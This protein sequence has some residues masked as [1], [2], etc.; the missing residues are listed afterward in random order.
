MTAYLGLAAVYVVLA[1][2]VLVVTTLL[3]GLLWDA[4]LAKSEGVTRST[5]LQAARVVVPLSVVALFVVALIDPAPF[6]LSCHC[7]GHGL[8]H[9]HLCWL[10]PHHAQ[11]MIA[12]AV[13]V[14]LPLLGLFA[15]RAGLLI[16]RVVRAEW[17]VARVR[18]L[19]VTQV[20]GIDVRLADCPEVGAF[21]A[22][23]LRPLVVFDRTLFEHLSPPHRDAIVLHEAAHQARRDPLTNV[24]L[25]AA[26]AVLPRR[27]VEPRVSGWQHASEERCDEAAAIELNSSVVVAE[28]LLEVGRSRHPGG[29]RPAFG[30]SAAR[31]QLKGRV[32]RLLALDPAT[33]RYR[34]QSDLLSLSAMFAAALMLVALAPG[35]LVL[36]TVE[37]VLGHVFL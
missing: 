10:H 19:P 20:R 3:T 21:T 14:A 7:E 1:A 5:H 30:C 26:G 32:A 28:A 31:G 34:H 18:A 33:S 36:H 22:G 24:M 8:H 17:Q 37:I 16:A 29:L 15:V 25:H 4:W 35:D 6:A 27:W 2:V 12:V 11:P 13:A 23:I 9:P